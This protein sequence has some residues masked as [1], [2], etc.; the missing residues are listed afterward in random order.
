MHCTDFALTLNSYFRVTE[1]YSALFC[2]PQIILPIS[3]VITFFANSI[4][5]FLHFTDL[6]LTL[7]SQYYASDLYSARFIHHPDFA[8]TLNSHIRALFCSVLHCTDHAPTLR[9]QYYVSEL[10][11]AVFCIAQTLLSLSAVIIAYPR[12][13]LLF[14]CIAQILLPLPIVIIAHQSS[15]LLFLS[16]HLPCFHSQVY[17]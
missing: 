1:L 8:L 5:L 15:I 12:A 16:L 9:S 11:S 4:L 10:Y 14:L 17:D 6:A 13:I 2:I 3:T 7:N